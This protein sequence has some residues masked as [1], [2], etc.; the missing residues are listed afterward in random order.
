[1]V[2]VRTDLGSEYRHLGDHRKRCRAI[3]GPGRRNGVGSY[4]PLLSHVADQDGRQAER[5][6]HGTQLFSL[7]Q[8]NPSFPIRQAQGECRTASPKILEAENRH[9]FKAKMC[10][11]GW[12]P[13]PG[14]RL[15][16]SPS[17][18]AGEV[19]RPCRGCV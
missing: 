2:R 4:A 8:G 17:A 18:V 3:R 6:G 12:F 5:A 13:L 1:M 10:L 16:L 11:F 15:A 14:G 7:K 9:I 19:A